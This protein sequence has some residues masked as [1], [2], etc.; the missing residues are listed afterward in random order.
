MLVPRVPMPWRI[1]VIAVIVGACAG[2]LVGFVRGLDYLPTL[3]FAV[4]EGAVL[5]G[6]PATL[7]GFVLTAVWSS[8]TAVRRR[9]AVVD[10]QH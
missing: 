10:R 6:V 2:A 9:L 3:P 1:L 7:L 5:I 4:I 8:G